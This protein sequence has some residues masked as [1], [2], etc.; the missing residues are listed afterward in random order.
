M[1]PH[2]AIDSYTVP[3]VQQGIN[4]H[5]ERAISLAGSSADI[6]VYLFSDTDAAEADWAQ[7]MAEHAANP[8]E[9]RVDYQT[10]RRNR[11]ERREQ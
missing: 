5:I 11:L 3:A 2:G 4:V 1:I 10:Y 6:R 9:E 7:M 8:N